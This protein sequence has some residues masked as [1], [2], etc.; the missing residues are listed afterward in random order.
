MTEWVAPHIGNLPFYVPG[1]PIEELEAELGISEAIKLASNENPVGPSPR[2]VAA[3]QKALGQLHRYPEGGSVYLR[4]RLAELHRVQMEQILVGNGSNEILDLIAKTFLR[5]G[6]EGIY[7]EQAFVVYPMAVQS[8]NGVR[9]PVPLKSFTHDLEAMAE[10]ITPRTRLIFIANPNNPTGTAVGAAE[11]ERFLE[12]VPAE[13]IV[14]CDEA[15]FEYVERRDFPR[16]FDYLARGSNLF[17]LR[18]FSKIYGLAGLRIGYLVGRR[19]LV[20]YVHRVREPFNVNSLA[21]AAALG[22]LE[23]GEHVARALEVNAQGKKFLYAL[24]TELG[25]SF[26]PTEAN[27]VLVRVEREKEIYEAL[28]REGVIVRPMS[29]WG[30]AG[31]LRV[32]IGLPAEN[33]RFARALRKVLRGG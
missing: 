22:A 7:A 33:E 27:F 5:P 13:V 1:K 29:G 8:V 17:I 23:D 21:Q 30:L 18:T 9:V 28:L 24:F 19:E 10:R 32:T 15:Y 26:V 2:A 20:E 4:R 14:V 11:M 25:L 12:R 31:H 3:L 6:E 16:S